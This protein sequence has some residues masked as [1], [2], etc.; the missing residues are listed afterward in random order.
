[1]S[2]TKIVLALLAGLA[3][4]AAVGLLFAPEAGS[5]TQAKLA[6]SLTSFGDSIKETALGDIDHLLKAFKT[7]LLDLLKLDTSER[8]ATELTED[9]EHA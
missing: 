7:K 3:A 5:E 4:G 9:F 6:E 8:P 2:D 1:M